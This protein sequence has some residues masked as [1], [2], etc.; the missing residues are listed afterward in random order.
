MCNFNRSSP[1]HGHFPNPHAFAWARSSDQV[2]LSS[3]VAG[4]Q[5]VDFMG[6]V[7]SDPAERSLCVFSLQKGAKEEET[8][9]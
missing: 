4:D 9:N 5:A 2:D 6:V 3:P 1:S 7:G 8:N